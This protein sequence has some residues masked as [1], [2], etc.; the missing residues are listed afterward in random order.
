M[1]FDSEL[2]LEEHETSSVASSISD[3]PKKDVNQYKALFRKE[4]WALPLHQQIE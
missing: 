4:G 3:T 1:S 2:D